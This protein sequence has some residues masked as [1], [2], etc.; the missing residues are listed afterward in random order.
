VSINALELKKLIG[1]EIASVRDHRITGY[2]KKLLVEPI[3]T[4]RGWD[5]GAPNQEY[6]CWS[7]LDDGVGGIVYCAHGFGPQYPWGLVLTSGDANPPMSMG[8]DTD[9]FPTFLDAFFA[10]QM[11]IPLPIWQVFEL[12]T[13]TWDVGGAVTG[14]LEWGAAWRH[15]EALRSAHPDSR[16]IVRQPISP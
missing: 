2:V 15:C 6:P 7:V 14:E 3:I 10:S 13:D 4:M 8:M 5:Y 9:W 1:I 11:A 16:F 12:N